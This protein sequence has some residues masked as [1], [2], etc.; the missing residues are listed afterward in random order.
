MTKPD[1]AQQQRFK[2]ARIHLL[3]D[4]SFYGTLSTCL[5]NVIDPEVETSATNGKYIKWNPDYLD[6]LNDDELKGVM[7]HNILHVANGHTWRRSSRDVA[8]WQTACDKTIN[9]ILDKS[10]LTLP[11]GE[12]RPMPNEVGKAAESLYHAPPPGKGGGPGQGKGNPPPPQKRKGSGKGSGGQQPPQPPGCGAVEDAPPDEAQELEAKWK[13]SVAQAAEAA[14]SQGNLPGDLERFVD[15]IV[16]P[17]IPWETILR[18][19]V[20]RTARND[21]NWSKPNRRYLS[22]GIVLPTLVSEEIPEIVIAVDTSGSIGQKEMD[23]FAAEVSGVL[24]AYETTIHVIYVDTR[25]AHHHTVTRADLPL[26]ME[27][28]GGGGTAFEPAF[29]W[30]EKRG[31]T[32]ACLIYLTDGCGSFP[33]EEPAYPTL[34]VMTSDVKAPFGDTVELDIHEGEGA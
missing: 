18:D 6:K 22:M 14:K 34:W 2:R 10:G 29:R 33:N 8:A 30:V 5:E 15:E 23:T 27:P 32:P 19:F 4:H 9:S 1:S 3:L 21:Y 7:C 28:K 11:P 17:K 24:G 26:V 16:N 12:I 31:L 13:V 20:E 25:V